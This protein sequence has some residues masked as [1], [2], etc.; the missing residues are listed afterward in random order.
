MM[1]EHYRGIKIPDEV[2]I[3]EKFLNEDTIPTGYVVDNKNKNMLKNV[4]QKAQTFIPKLD[5]SRNQMFDEFGNALFEKIEGQI[6]SFK[7]GEFKLK[8]IDKGNYVNKNFCNCI[9]SVKDK[10]FKIAI[11]TKLLLNCIAN[12][13]FTQG[14]CNKNIYLGWSNN[15]LGIFTKD[16]SEYKIA[17]KDE[18]FRNLPL[19]STYEVGSVLQDPTTTYLYLGETYEHFK[20]LNVLDV[21]ARKGYLTR[22]DIY[23]YINDAENKYVIYSTPKKRYVY[24]KMDIANTE[25]LNDFDSLLLNE[26]FIDETKIIFSGKK[27]NKRKITSIDL[28]DENIIY[29]LALLHSTLSIKASE[30]NYK[31]LLE[32]QDLVI[33][34]IKNKQ[35]LSLKEY[36]YDN[37]LKKELKNKIKHKFNLIL[38]TIENEL[39]IKENITYEDCVAI[40]EKYTKGSQ[41]EFP[42]ISE[43]NFLEKLFLSNTSLNEYDSSWDEALKRS[44]AKITN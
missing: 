27:L 29:T 25:L 44:Y 11:N 8:L 37:L 19:D 18:Y 24:L 12:N 14:K 2:I 35:I 28:T 5:I 41:S 26:K 4:M 6:H 23:K 40:I 21:V 13:S 15:K 43:T 38:N 32:E 17:Q 20:M 1:I 39:N 31:N 9:L 42:I 34:N 7:N 30:S 22:A 36:E 10:Q 16:M 3:I 33:K